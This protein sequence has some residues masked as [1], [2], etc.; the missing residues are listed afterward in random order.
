[1]TLSTPTVIGVAP[2]QAMRRY[3]RTLGALEQVFDVRFVIA[4]AEHADPKALLV[5][6][7]GAQFA[8]AARRGVS[9]YVVESDGRAGPATPSVT[10][11][12]LKEVDSR[13]CGRTLTDDRDGGSVA[14][15]PL[16]GDVV[17]AERGSRPVWLRRRTGA[18]SVDLVPLPPPCLADDEC[19]RNHLLPGRFMALLPLID[20]LRRVSNN[21]SY[22]PQPRRACFVIDDANLRR[23]KYGHL[24]FR[25]LV[26]AARKHE[27]HVTIATIPFD[28]W[29]INTDVG[30]FFLNHRDHV[31]LAMHG[32]NHTFGELG[33]A[34]PEDR[35][36]A[37]LAQG[38]RRLS[39][40]TQRTGVEP[41]RVIVAPHEQLSEQMMRA[42][43]ALGFDAASVDRHQF[44]LSHATR[45]RPL[46]GWEAADSITANFPVIPRFLFADDQDEVVLAAFLD[47]PIVVHGHHEHGGV[48][49]DVVE[50]A[51]ETINALGPVT[52][53]GLGDLAR[54]S[55]AC[56]RDD[57]TLYVHLF[58]RRAQV[59]VQS[60]IRTLSVSWSAAPLDGTVRDDVVIG[61]HLVP[62]SPE[63]TEAVPVGGP[64]PTDVR[65]CRRDAVNAAAVPRPRLHPWRIPRRLMAETR[66]RLR[67]RRFRSD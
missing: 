44:A 16:P 60:G 37:V 48:L 27:F 52:W 66:D 51:A 32:N 42:A 30:R 41:A 9:C 10:F 15:H 50:R 18:A 8:E 11:T 28:T 23:W 39:R 2:A 20:F 55:Y 65:L 47:Q 31:P 3:E 64:G 53:M 29:R 43:A 14:L 13:L 46:L 6:G 5:L 63:G 1:M 4:N 45:E 49:I 58:S 21:G 38:L 67:L 26:S 17:I 33:S 22:A 56:D 40:V 35:C 36:L 54:A 34:W 7:Q 57:D 12:R 62:L 19:L 59:D 61:D 25:H 24:D